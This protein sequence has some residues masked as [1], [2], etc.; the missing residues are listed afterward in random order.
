[1]GFIRLMYSIGCDTDDDFLRVQVAYERLDYYF[2]S[3]ART[4]K[5]V[6]LEENQQRVLGAIND[7]PIE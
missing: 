7:L 4:R 1:M 3:I 2:F 6:L 5:T